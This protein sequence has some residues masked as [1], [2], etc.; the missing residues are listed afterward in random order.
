MKRFARLFIALDQTRSTNAK[1]DALAQYFGAAPDDDRLWTVALLSGRRPKRGVTTAALRQWAAER[2]GLPLWLVEDSYAQVGDLAETIALLLPP[3]AARH[4]ESLSFY[5]NI[6]KSIHEL[7]HEDARARILRLWDTLDPT[8]RLVFNKLLTGGFRLGVSQALMTRA[9]ARATG[10]P[11][12]ELA[13]RLMG[14]WTPDTTGWHDLIHGDDPRATL[15]RPYPFALAH[16]LDAP[17]E[18]LGPRADWLAEWKWDGV[19]AQLVARGGDVFVWSRGGELMSDRFPEIAALAGTLP[20]GA[21]I[22]GELLPWHDGA[23][24]SFN[25]LQRRLGR[26]TVPRK[27]LREV[28]VVLLAYDLLE[29]RGDDIRRL[30]LAARRDRLAAL[31]AAV[32]ED[33][34]LR[35][36]P[37]LQADDWPSTAAER[38]T[39]RAHRAEGLMLKRR[40]APIT[41]GGSRAAGG[42]G[43]STR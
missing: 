22:D 24:L 42:N 14:D 39:A 18:T 23:P 25:A 33:G 1:V 20:D 34:P 19:R 9:L 15:S 7:S 43:N 5:I 27:L 6:L 10:K 12:A 4:S 11:A 30:P 37:A 38:A 8:E 31:L 13:H 29:D 35:L 32:P 28:P 2:A 17:A 16:Q 36:S 41:P 3:P 40:D 21:V 26:K